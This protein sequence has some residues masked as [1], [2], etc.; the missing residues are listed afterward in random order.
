M[1]GFTQHHFLCMFYVYII[2]SKLNDELYFGST[3]NLKKRLKDH[4]D[5]KVTLTNRYKPW[6]LMY[7]ETYKSDKLARD[8][9]KKIK[10][11][12][13]SKRELIK[14][15][16]LEVLKKSG[17]GFTLIEL[18][19][20]IA[21]LAIIGGMSVPF[22][23]SF[24]VT[25]DLATYSDTVART[26]RR[27]QAQARAGQN[28][29]SWG[30]FFDTASNDITLFYGDDY[31]TRDITFDQ[32]ESFASSFTLSTDFSDEIYFTIFSGDPSTTGSVTLT[33]QNNDTKT[34]SINSLGVISI[35]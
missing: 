32:T 27:A 9:E 18:I 5:G 23:Q 7:Y 8:R 35:Q 21:M 6:V 28:T 10:Q 4:N 26:L 1:R 20:V 2:K 13:N 12:S 15:A 19:L 17:A 22:F 24:Q 33:S 3:S 29:N 16:G 11:H 14:R 25:S 30:V 34:I 31:A